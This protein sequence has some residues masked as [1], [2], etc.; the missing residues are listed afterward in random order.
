[1]KPNP[2]RDE[3]INQMLLSE[4]LITAIA[5]IGVYFIFRNFWK[6]E[7]KRKEEEKNK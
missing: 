5:F 6:K 2:T 4:I 3:F 1:M 7:N